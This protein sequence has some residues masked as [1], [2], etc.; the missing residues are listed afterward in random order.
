[1]CSRVGTADPQDKQQRITDFTFYEHDVV[2]AKWR[3]I[4]AN[5]AEETKQSTLTDAEVM[6][7]GQYVD[8][9]TGVNVTALWVQQQERLKQLM[10]IHNS[11]YG[12]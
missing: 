5:T 4:G 8:E 12:E 11:I 6:Q 7:Y 1:M 10:E 9:K 2:Y 3:S